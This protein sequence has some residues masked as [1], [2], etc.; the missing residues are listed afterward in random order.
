MLASPSMGAAALVLAAVAVLL[1]GSEAVLPAYAATPTDGGSTCGR[2]AEAY[3]LPDGQDYRGTVNMTE[4]GILCKMWPSQGLQIG[5]IP[6]D[7]A[8]AVGNHGYC[9]NAN[10]LE[11]PGSFA[12]TPG[13]GY[14]FCT[15]GPVRTGSPSTTPTVLFWPLSGAIMVADGSHIYA[16]GV[17]AFASETSPAHTHPL[18]LNVSTSVNAYVVYEA[19]QPLRARARHTVAST[20]TDA[21]SSIRFISTDSIVYNQP[22]FVEL[23]G[24]TSA[25][26]VLLYRNEDPTN[27]TVYT[28]GAFRL[29]KSTDIVAVVSRR[30]LLFARYRLNITAPPLNV[31]PPSGTY[32][33]GVNVLVS[34]PQPPA[35][36]YMYVNRSIEWK[37][38][39][40]LLF[41]WTAVGTSELDFRALHVQGITSME[42]VVYTVLPASPAIIRPDP[43]MVYHRPVNVTC[44]APLGAAVPLSVYRDTAMQDAVVEHVFS[45]ILGE[46]G[47]YTVT[48]SY[49]DDLLTT[50]TSSAALQIVAVPMQRLTCTP[51]CGVEFPAIALSLRTELK[52]SNLLPGALATSWSVCVSATR[53]ARIPVVTRSPDADTVFVYEVF[54]SEPIQKPTAMEVYVTAHSLDPLEADSP[55]TTCAYILYSLGAS[56]ARVFTAIPKCATAGSPTSS[57]CIVAV[58]RELVSCLHFYSTELLSMDALGPIAVMHIRGLTEAITSDVYTRMGACLADLQRLGVLSI[59]HNETSGENVLATSWHVATPTH[60]ATEVYTGV[61]ITVNVVGFRA[62]AGM[63]HLV[64]NG[65][66]CEDVG[67][68]PETVPGVSAYAAAATGSSRIPLSTNNSIHLTFRVPIQGQYRLCGYVSGALYEVPFIS[69]TV[70]SVTSAVTQYL[71]VVAQ[72]WPA[73]AA[74]SA[75]ECGGRVPPDME[76]V[77]LSFS[78]AATPTGAFPSPSYSYNSATWSTAQLPFDAAAQLS[79]PDSLSIGPL[80]RQTQPLEV[81]DTSLGVTTGASRRCVFFVSATSLPVQPDVTYFFYTVNASEVPDSLTGV[82]LLLKGQFQPSEVIVIDVYGRGP[83][84]MADDSASSPL[85][86]LRRVTARPSPATAYEVAL[87]DAVLGLEA[88]VQ[89]DP[90]VIHVTL[91][92]MQ[93][94]AVPSTV[95]LSPLAL[96][97][98][99]CTSCASRLCYDGKCV[100]KDNQTKVVS[101]CEMESDSKGDSHS[102]D[103]TN[104]SSPSGPDAGESIKSVSMWQRLLFLLAYLGLLAVIAA[105]IFIAVKRSS[106]RHSHASRSENITLEAS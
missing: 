59:L 37:P 25:T 82:M 104:S 72:P 71:H 27:P 84:T 43:S 3:Y 35:T 36:Y 63:Y 91:D 86:L 32:V 77:A 57:A 83:A 41:K 80:S 94:T 58:K 8:T 52:A 48:C 30:H 50:H 38:L 54:H 26:Q 102:D 92:G 95:A 103:S 19:A 85:R 51:P 101:V 45:V 18:L 74:A 98:E 47:A 60:M 44:T 90:Y 69:S 93:V 7:P 14:E 9:R 67:V 13:G 10:G 15:I 68:L 1:L 53:G 6:V 81:V 88:G 66:S 22:I 5:A 56:P 40:T 28:G 29:K 62:D 46:P 73:V 61:P 105:Y 75:E 31:Y 87:P 96:A 89:Q 64:R 12:A 39:S 78:R 23:Q 79:G 11:R 99:T 65:Y 100:C 21:P 16:L 24:I 49:A 70:D 55:Q 34:D 106:G 76:G 4:S 17:E 2:S 33:G 42:R 20:A 97:M